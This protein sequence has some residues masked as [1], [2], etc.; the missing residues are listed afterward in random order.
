MFLVDLGQSAANLS[1]G[2]TIGVVEW[3]KWSVV[4][5]AE[6]LGGAWKRV[7]MTMEAM[8]PSALDLPIGMTTKVIGWLWRC[9]VSK[10]ETLDSARTSRDYTVLG[11]GKMALIPCW[12]LCINLK[13]NNRGSKRD[14]RDREFM[15]ISL[16]PTYVHRVKSKGLYCDQ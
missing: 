9:G 11:Q 3:P 4:E 13:Y 10:A 7:T 14:K 2:V 1:N 6:F 16:W 15:W 5:C 8:E 12:D